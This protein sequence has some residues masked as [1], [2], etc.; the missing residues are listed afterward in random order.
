MWHILLLVPPLLAIVWTIINVRGFATRPRRLL[1]GFI[2]LAA[3]LYFVIQDSLD[4]TGVYPFVGAKLLHDLAACVTV[5]LLHLLVCYTIGI[6]QGLRFFKISMCLLVLMIPDVC[7]MFAR[8]F[9]HDRLQRDDAFN[10]IVFSFNGRDS[11]RMQLYSFIVIVQVLIEINRIFVLRRIFAVRRLNL[12]KNAKSFVIEC[13]AICVWITVT[14]VLPL[15]FYSNPL[16]NSLMLAGYSLLGT[17]FSLSLCYFFNYNV[18]VD[19][20]N[21]PVEMENDTDSTL[22]ADILNLIE[23][24]RVYRN[25]SLRIDDLAS[26]LSTNRTYVARAFRLKFGGTF[27]EVMNRCRV[28]HAKRLMLEEPKKRMEE[29]ALES[30]FSSSNF[31]GR[32]FKSLEGM[33]PTT[34]RSEVRSGKV[35]KSRPILPVRDAEAAEKKENVKG[36]IIPEKGMTTEEMLGLVVIDTNEQEKSDAKTVVGNLAS[37]GVGARGDDTTADDATSHAGAAANAVYSASA[38]ASPKRVSTPPPPRGRYGR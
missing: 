30:G 11:L 7:S 33:T 36:W 35:P 10:Y 27:T 25:S 1:I 24:D 28:E 16:Y 20:D 4:Q 22:A 15:E 34:W 9:E 37:A 6:T 13:I 21:N 3:I 18:V 12:T 17:M 26:M 8:I 29:V 38:D 14:V 23:Q 5:P 19:N 2:S 31:F 32:V